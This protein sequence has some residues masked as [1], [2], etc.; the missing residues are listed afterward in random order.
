MCLI[1]LYY[2]IQQVLRIRKERKIIL[3]LKTE[4]YIIDIRSGRHGIIGW[5]NDSSYK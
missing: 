2:M 5:N 1:I 3:L 4:Y